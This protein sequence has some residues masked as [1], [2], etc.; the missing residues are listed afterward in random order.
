L[1]INDFQNNSRIPQECG[2]TFLDTD[3]CMHLLYYRLIYLGIYALGIWDE[4][5]KIH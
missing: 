2:K 4:C 1:K 5:V 3:L